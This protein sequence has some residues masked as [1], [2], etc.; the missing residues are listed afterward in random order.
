MNL[1]SPDL[2]EQELTAVR[3]E[4]GPYVADLQFKAGRI[5]AIQPL[6]YTY[7]LLADLTPWGYEPNGRW[8]YHSYAAARA[9]LDAWSGEDGT[10]PSGWH[11]HPHSG[12]R[13]NP[14]GSEYVR[15]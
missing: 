8:C 14:D 2:L 13:R 1:D 10:E 5:C 15:P 12:R 7:A 3:T 6:M 9:A 11:R 4:W